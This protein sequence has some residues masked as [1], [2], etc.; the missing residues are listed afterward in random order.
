MTATTP[1]TGPKVPG[2][3]SR[4]QATM[5]LR[6][7]HIFT[8]TRLITVISEASVEAIPATAAS[9]PTPPLAKGGDRRAVSDAP[10]WKGGDRRAVSDAP[11]WKGGD[12]RGVGDPRRIQKAQRGI[13]DGERG[14]PARRFRRPA[15][16]LRTETFRQPV[17]ETPTGATGTVAL[18]NCNCAVPAES[19][20]VTTWN[21]FLWNSGALWGPLVVPPGFSVIHKHKTKRMKRQEYYP[22]RVDAQ[23]E[24]LGNFA[25]KLL[26]YAATLG[27][28]NA[29]RDAIVLDCLWLIYLIGSPA[30]PPPGA[31]P[32]GGLASASS[33]SPAGGPPPPAP[34]PNRSP[35]SS[36]TPRRAPAR[37]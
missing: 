3:P 13:S 2:T 27:V 29:R 10:F 1:T 4:S 37:R 16:N 22:Q 32:C 28:T 11:F 15:E 36:P 33:P 18:P 8:G 23:P 25:D 17:G 7:R 30:P 5:K 9:S 24:W 6:W 20:P 26:T 19:R 14:R 21:Q 35:T 31:P 34:G 12:R